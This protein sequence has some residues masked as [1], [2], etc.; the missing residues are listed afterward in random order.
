VPP[1]TPRNARTAAGWGKTPYEP[2]RLDAQARD[3][4]GWN[5]EWVTVVLDAD[6]A[7]QTVRT[8]LD[9]GLARSVVGLDAFPARPR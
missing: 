7:L 4:D 5:R 2:P 3:A 9:V 1:S 6:N 8:A